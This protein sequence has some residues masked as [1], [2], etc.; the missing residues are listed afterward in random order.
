MKRYYSLARVSKV[1]EPF[2]PQPKEWKYRGRTQINKIFRSFPIS[3][4]SNLVS[5]APLPE[6]IVRIYFSQ[7]AVKNFDAQS[8]NHKNS[9][10]IEGFKAAWS[11]IS[12]KF[13]RE[14]GKRKWP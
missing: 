6:E 12:T 8:V 9:D 13:F 11:S 10:P 14:G 3:D 4:I 7:E 1:Y 5:S 2:I